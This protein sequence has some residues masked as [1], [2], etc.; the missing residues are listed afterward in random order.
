MIRGGMSMS[1]QDKSQPVNNYEKIKELSIEEMAEFLTLTGANIYKKLN[2]KLGDDE[3][4]ELYSE[5]MEMLLHKY[6]QYIGV[7]G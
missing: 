6:P 2:V 1:N 3:I 4:R 7:V 5:M